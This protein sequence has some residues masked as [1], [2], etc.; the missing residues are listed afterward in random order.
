MVVQADLLNADP[1]LAR[2]APEVAV[3]PILPGARRH[4]PDADLERRLAH[5]TIPGVSIKH[6]YRAFLQKTL[7]FG[8][9]GFT[10]MMVS[11]IPCFLR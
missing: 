3:H 6:T 7:L 8:S 9:S 2:L 4:A 10:G 11:T 1:L 5:R